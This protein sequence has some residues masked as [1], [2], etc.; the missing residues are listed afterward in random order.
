[1]ASMPQFSVLRTAALALLLA[2]APAFAAPFAVQLGDIRIVLDTPPGFADASE[3][4]SPRVLELA[5]QLTSASNRILLFGLTDSDFRRFSVGDAPEMRRYLIAV[6]PRAQERYA[7]SPSDFERYVADVTRSL[8][9][10]PEATDYHKYLEKV[11]E[12]QPVLLSELR[13]EEAL[14][15]LM[16]GARL[17]PIESQHLFTWD[18]PQPRYLLSTTTL[19]LLHERALSL[20]IYTGYDSPQDL[21]WLLYTTKRWVEDLLRINRR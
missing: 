12:G 10:P 14:V 11:P 15:S 20:S 3:T 21:D 6:T 16:Q 4:G 1:M 9:K 2:A 5:E 7:V 8:G 13:R 19:L 17:A 18:K